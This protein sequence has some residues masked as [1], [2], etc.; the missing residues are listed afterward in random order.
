LSGLGNIRKILVITVYKYE[1]NASLIAEFSK[2]WYKN[3]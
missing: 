3:H 2:L 1:Y